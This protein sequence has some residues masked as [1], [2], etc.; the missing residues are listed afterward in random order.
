MKTQNSNASMVTRIRRVLVGLV[1][2]SEIAETGGNVFVFIPE[3]V[4]R[5]SINMCHPVEAVESFNW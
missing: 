5:L 4:I 3:V 2:K 1:I